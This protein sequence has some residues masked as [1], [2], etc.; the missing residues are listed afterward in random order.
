VIDGTAMFVANRLILPDVLAVAL[1]LLTS[2]LAPAFTLKEYVPATSPDWMN[3]VAARPGT[4]TEAWN[5]GAHT[6]P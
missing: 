3:V 6:D 2:T 1:V 5:A 4:D